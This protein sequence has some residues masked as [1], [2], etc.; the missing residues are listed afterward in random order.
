MRLYKDYSDPDKFRLI[1]GWK[2][3]NSCLPGV[4]HNLVCDWHQFSGTLFTSGTSSNIIKCFDADEEA[5]VQEL[6]VDAVA[7]M[8]SLKSEPNGNLILSGFSD[9]SIKL[10][11]R[12]L[13]PIQWFAVLT[14]AVAT[15]QYGTGCC[16]DASFCNH[17][18]TEFLSANASGDLLLWDIRSVNPILKIE[19]V[20]GP[21]IHFATHAQAPLMA[22]FNDKIA[23]NVMNFQG[24][25]LGNITATRGVISRTI[26]DCQNLIFHPKRLLLACTSATGTH[27]FQS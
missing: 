8:T 24:R 26:I 14:S 9:S 22:T 2:A 21:L 18:S 1:S 25:L 27:L 5:C 12:R 3:S 20:S 17:E 19:T 16:L 23:V 7:S 10:F 6:S 11:D 4:Y 15:Y 13:P